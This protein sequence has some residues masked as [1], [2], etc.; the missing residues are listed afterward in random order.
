MCR[1]DSSPYACYGC[2]YR[3][4]HNLVT[5]S[6]NQKEALSYASSPCHVHYADR[7]FYGTLELEPPKAGFNNDDMF[8][9]FGVLV[10]EIISGKKINSFTNQELGN[11]LLTYAWRNWNEGTDWEV[12][13]PI[14][15]DGS[16]SEIM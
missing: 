2:I 5:N 4:I 7:S 12:V 10:L 9:S 11:S 13:D 8:I 1:G 15:R 3:S 14:L 6:P 16:R